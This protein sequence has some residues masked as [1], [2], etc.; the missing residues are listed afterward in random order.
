MQ[1]VGSMVNDHWQTCDIDISYHFPVYDSALASDEELQVVA[2]EFINKPLFQDVPLWRMMLIPEFQSG[3]ALII[4]IHHAYADGMALMKVLL[5][6]MD[7]GELIKYAQKQQA[8]QSKSA[9]KKQNAGLLSRLQPF[10]P[11][12]GKWLETLGLV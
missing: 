3:S 5:Q 4:R 2:T 8:K 1:P 12:Q 9:D 6:M 11:G 7:E 10:M